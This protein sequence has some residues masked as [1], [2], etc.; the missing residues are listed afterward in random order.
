M[1]GDGRISKNNILLSHTGSIHSIKDLWYQNPLILNFSVYLS[2]AILYVSEICVYFAV[3]SRPPWRRRKWYCN[4]DTDLFFPYDN[5]FSIFNVS[6]RTRR[7]VSSFESCFVVKLRRNVKLLDETEVFYFTKLR[8]DKIKNKRM[9]ADWNMSMDNSRN[10]TGK[11]TS[12]EK[13][14]PIAMWIA[15]GSNSGLLY[16]RSAN[17]R[18]MFLRI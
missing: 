14:C 9:V 15:S 6:F 11:A 17:Y 7:S 5:L 3:D 12:S 16:D 4:N 10:D 13:T 1:L 2:H 8:I 18:L